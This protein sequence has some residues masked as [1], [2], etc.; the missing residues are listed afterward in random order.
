VVHSVGLIKDLIISGCTVRLWK[1]CSVQ[2]RSWTLQIVKEGL[3]TLK[4]IWYVCRT[5]RDRRIKITIPGHLEQSIKPT[6]ALVSTWSHFTY[7][8]NDTFINNFL[9]HARF[10]TLLLFFCHQTLLLHNYIMQCLF[11]CYWF[12]FHRWSVGADI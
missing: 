8:R 9:Q 1:S 10:F 3:L 12:L 11:I 4:H 2:V 7:I 6:S 5:Y